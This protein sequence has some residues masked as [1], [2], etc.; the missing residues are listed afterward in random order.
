MEDFFE[1]DDDNYEIFYYEVNED[2][3]FTIYDNNTVF[4]NKTNIT[5]DIAYLLDTEYELLFS[6]GEVVYLIGD[7][8]KVCAGLI[9]DE[10]VIWTKV[11][12]IPYDKSNYN[13]KFQDDGRLI[14]VIGSEEITY[15]YSEHGI[16]TSSKTTIKED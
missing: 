4:L 10:S 16:K 8:N 14:V 9:D 11:F 13:L 1:I 15:D 7:D 3:K 2:I 12:D 6:N 5:P